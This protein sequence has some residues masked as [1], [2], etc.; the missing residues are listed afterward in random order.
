MRSAGS[1]CGEPGSRVLS[2][3]ISGES[4][5]SVTPGARSA[6]RTHSSS[7]RDSVSR[8]FASSIATSH[9]EIAE[10]STP[11]RALAASSSSIAPAPSC[12]R[13]PSTA[14]I[15]TCVSSTTRPPVPPSPIRLPLL[16]RRRDDVAAHGHR[17]LQPAEQAR[18][19][20]AFL[21][22]HRH[23]PRDRLAVTRHHD[24]L[25]RLADPVQQL[26]PRVLQLAGRDLPHHAR[27]RLV[28]AVLHASLL[29]NVGQDKLAN[30]CA[31]RNGGT[32][33]AAC[34]PL[35]SARPTREVP[36]RRRSSVRS[37]AAGSTRVARRA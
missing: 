4:G 31:R 22:L 18:A 17:A 9:T 20:R 34:S 7:G 3:A 1:P 30:I 37:T 32:A 12:A 25:P 10:T 5:S 8:P 19:L 13:S 26:V 28:L 29:A 35:D 2:T 14:Q 11:P 6:A 16:A 24:L 15:Q 27:C 21:R 36:P 23:Q 33:F